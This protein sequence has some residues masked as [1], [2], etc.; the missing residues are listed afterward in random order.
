MNLWVLS[1]IAVMVGGFV[2]R[3]NPLVV[4]AGAALATGLAAGM[5]PMA[6]L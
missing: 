1:G 2:W 3:L 5:D 4:V 6:I